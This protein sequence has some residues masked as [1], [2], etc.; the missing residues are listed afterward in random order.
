M[1]NAFELLELG[2]RFTLSLPLDQQTS[3]KCGIYVAGAKQFPFLPQT[4]ESSNLYLHDMMNAFS[5]V[6]HDIAR[7]N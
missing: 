1:G 7:S 3:S 6:L 4:F 5:D 2:G